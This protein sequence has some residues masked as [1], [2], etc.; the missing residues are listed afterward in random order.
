VRILKSHPLLGLINSYLID[1]PQPSNISYAW[2]GGVRVMSFIDYITCCPSII[3]YL[4]LCCQNAIYNPRVFTSQE[5]NKTSGRVAEYKRMKKCGLPRIVVYLSGSL[6]GDAKKLG[7]HSCYHFQRACLK[8][9]ISA[10][11]KDIFT[12]DRRC[13][14]SQEPL[15]HSVQREH[16]NGVICASTYTSQDIKRI[17]I[18]TYGSKR[19]GVPLWDLRGRSFHSSCVVTAKG[20][21]QN[22]ENITA[23]TNILKGPSKIKPFWAIKNR[24]PISEVRAILLGKLHNGKYYKILEI[25]AKPEFLMGCY[26]LIKSKPANMT[27]G[28]SLDGISK[29]WFK[30]ISESLLN[31]RFKFSPSR[32]MQILNGKTRP[33][34]TPRHKI[35]QKAMELILSTIWKPQFTDYSHSFRPNRS[36]H[37]ALIPIYL[38]GSNYNWVIQGDITECFDMIPHKLIR[39]TIEEQIG[40]TRFAQLLN[41]FLNAGVL[42]VDNK[43]VGKYKKGIPQG[44]ILSPVFA[45]I[46]LHKLDL[47]IEKVKA[48]FEIGRKRKVTST[49]QRLKYIRSR[50]DDPIERNGI[51]IFKTSMVDPK[52]PNIRRLMYIRYADDFVIFVTGTFNESKHIKNNVK[53]FLKTH[54][55]L[56]LNDEKILITNTREKFTFLGAEIVKLSRTGYL[57]LTKPGV[58]RRIHPRIQVKA[59]ISKLVKILKLNGFI[60]TNRLGKHIPCA[61]TKITNLPHSAILQ[62][63]NAKLRGLYNFYSFASNY[64]KLRYII[65]LLQFSCAYTL[66]RK[67]KLNPFTRVFRKFGGTLTCPDTSI[68][69]E[70]PDTMKT[71]HKFK[72][73]VNLPRKATWNFIEYNPDL[74]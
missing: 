34:A 39:K 14:Y 60:R 16:Q 5:P 17:N 66:A 49:Y 12:K 57:S 58:R 31:G 20:N 28:V 32:Q 25:I 68:K 33:L 73:F 54:C 29:D 2:N 53:E 46:L 4:M 15:Q 19:L 72:K 48:N 62:F 42:T 37:S 8:Q 30:N 35:V 69:L 41:K 64:N 27:K 63:Y 65:Y 40:D 61:Y 7:T 11:L 18:R 47:Y 67:L 50:S 26:L 22:T 24:D 9:N 52:D 13:R 6:H 44:G 74:T 70:L 23:L 3:V 10:C 71:R 21:S 55:G 45:N 59:P 1:S 51:K 43:R 38:H 36:V 56:D